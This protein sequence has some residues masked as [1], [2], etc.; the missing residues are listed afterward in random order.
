MDRRYLEE[1]I[2]N[3]QSLIKCPSCG[4]P[5][6]TNMISI[7]GGSGQSFLVH[8]EC[9]LC[10][11][12]TLASVIFRQGKIGLGEKNSYNEIKQPEMNLPIS[13]SSFDYKKYQ[14]QKIDA[15]DVINMHEFLKKF[16]GDFESF[17]RG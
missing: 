12:P 4:S 9:S 14:G 17:L 7:V 3:I 8:L 2:K 10:G 15:N 1:L 6:K 16:N 5:Y 11:L 13:K